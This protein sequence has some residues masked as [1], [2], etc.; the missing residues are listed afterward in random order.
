MTNKELFTTDEWAALRDAP[1]MIAMATGV[2]GSS[3]LFGSIGEMFTSVKVIMEAA[4]SPNPLIKLF[5]SQ[6]EI[7]AAQESLKTFAHAADPQHMKEELQSTAIARAQA[8]LAALNA[9][10]PGDV[11]DYKT[12]IRSVAQRVAESSKEGGFL[13]FGGE[14][15]SEKEREFLARLDGALAS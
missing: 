11:N 7:K 5:G 9:K 8:A 10:A 3:G 4:D 6:E 12:W 15:V 13:G 1:H 14:R 2:A